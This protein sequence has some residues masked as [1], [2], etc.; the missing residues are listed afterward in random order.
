M[1]HVH[2]RF[3]RRRKLEREQKGAGH[4]AEPENDV[5]PLAIRN[6]K[7][8]MHQKLRRVLHALLNVL[9]HRRQQETTWMT[10]TTDEAL[11]VSAQARGSVELRRHRAQPSWE[12]LRERISR[13]RGGDRADANS[14][15]PPE[16]ADDLP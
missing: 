12:P 14:I 13:Q 15:A 11:A 2:D 1:S 10:T 9:P 8:T 5:N 16:G 7:Q 3:E 6:A 4:R